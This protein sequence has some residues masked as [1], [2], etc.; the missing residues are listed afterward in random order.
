MNV[1]PL[2]SL[3]IIAENHGHNDNQSD[4][5]NNVGSDMDAYNNHVIDESHVAARTGTIHTA[6]FVEICSLRTW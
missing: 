2:M 4:D 3:S 5:S 6:I 1:P